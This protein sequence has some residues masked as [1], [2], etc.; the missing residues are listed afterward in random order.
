MKHKSPTEPTLE[1]LRE[2][3]AR[4]KAAFPNGLRQEDVRI[5]ATSFGKANTDGREKMTYHTE[6][7]AIAM[8]DASTRKDEALSSEATRSPSPTLTGWTD[9]DSF[10]GATNPSGVAPSPTKSLGSASVEGTQAS[11]GTPTFTREELVGVMT[12][13]IDNLREREDWREA[14]LDALISAGA[15]KV[16]G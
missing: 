10:I 15:V 16:E 7:E 13:A 8:G 1:E 2:C 9:S 14:A 3:H 6:Q 12:M 4:I 5:S 11:S